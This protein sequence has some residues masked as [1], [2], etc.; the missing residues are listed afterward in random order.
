[1]EWSNAGH[2]PP[3]LIRAVGGPVLMDERHGPLLGVGHPGRKLGSA[4][5]GPGDLVLLYTDGLVEDRREP[6]DV[7]LQRLLETLSQSPATD[8]PNAVAD[9]ALASSLSG[10]TRRDDLCILAIQQPSESG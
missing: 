4:V 10:I 2:P 5:L 6:L 8:G 1:L 7:S 3:V 9:H